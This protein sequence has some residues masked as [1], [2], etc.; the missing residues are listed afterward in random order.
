VGFSGVNH[1]IVSS[2]QRRKDER[3]ADRDP[4]RYCA[5]RC[6]TLGYCD[7]FEDMFDLGE[8]DANI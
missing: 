3:M 2:V 8:F 7:V 5:D 6:V 1:D 4:M